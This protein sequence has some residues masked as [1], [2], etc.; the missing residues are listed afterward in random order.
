MNL[1]FESTFPPLLTNFPENHCT[2]NALLNV[3][4]NGNKLDKCGRVRAISMDL[5]KA[6]DALSHNLLIDKQ[7]AVD[8]SFNL[9]KVIRSYLA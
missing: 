8:L 3:L 2:E 5:Q 9:I 1:C 4:N 7:N 6:I